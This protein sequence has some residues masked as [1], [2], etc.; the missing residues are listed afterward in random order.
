MTPRL[1]AA[2]VLFERCGAINIC[3]GPLL[4]VRGS[5]WARWWQATLEAIRA[6]EQTDGV[7]T[8]AREEE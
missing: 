5:P 2:P 6:W 7:L 8:Q 4:C 1:D 3:H